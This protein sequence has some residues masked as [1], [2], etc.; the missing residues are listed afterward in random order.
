MDKITYLRYNCPY[1]FSIFIQR[2]QDFEK[3]DKQIAEL[4]KCM[5]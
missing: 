4:N 3:E 1:D 5:K 2:L